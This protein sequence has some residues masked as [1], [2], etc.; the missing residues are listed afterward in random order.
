MNIGKGQL[1]NNIDSKTHRTECWFAY[2]KFLAVS[3]SVTFQ[4]KTPNF[5]KSVFHMLPGGHF[6]NSRF[7]FIIICGMP[8]VLLLRNHLP[9]Y[10]ICIWKKRTIL[11]SIIIRVVSVQEYLLGKEANELLKNLIK[12]LFKVLKKGK[13][14]FDVV[15]ISS[16]IFS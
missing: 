3:S 2:I 11:H 5:K 15:F 4:T 12:V 9:K 1:T 7:E 13:I 16:T 8:W 10:R 6:Y 14:I